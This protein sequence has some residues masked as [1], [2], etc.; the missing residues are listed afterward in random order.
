MDR[1]A[2]FA[3]FVRAVDAGSFSAAGAALDMSPQ[4]VGKHV[5][6]LEQ[7]LGVRLLNRTTRRQSLTDFGQRF[8]ERARI[9]LAEVDIAEGMAAETRV[10][11]SGRLR[12][13]APVSFG[14]H[15]LAPRLPA[16]L[17]ACP[18]VQ[19]EL[20]MTNREVDLIE[21]G[22]DVVFRVGELR[23]SGLIARTLAPY[24][25]VLCAAPS[26]LKSSPPLRTPMD[27][28]HHECLLFLRGIYRDTWI[29]DGRNGRVSVPVSGQLS[30]DHGESLVQAALAGMGI[31]LQPSELVSA[32][33]E[34]GRL[35]PFLK[36]YHP[37]ARGLHMLYARDRRITPKLRSFLEFAQQNFGEH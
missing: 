29:F 17:A 32:A 34:Q 12:I 15:A 37:P 27:L 35:V 7:H 6:L 1:L 3:V 16:Y 25:L 4:L 19:V 8:Y 13:N 30:S 2:S 31:L 10:V 22:Y 9:I 14:T 20:T 21:E 5:R 18:E 24:R 36:D 33:I 23:D 26:Y 11:P 28:V